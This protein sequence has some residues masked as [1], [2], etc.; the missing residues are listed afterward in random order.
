MAV[1][2][3]LFVLTAYCCFIAALT[4]LIVTAFGDAWY[5]WPAALGS[6]GVLTAATAG[7]AWTLLRDRLRGRVIVPQKTIAV[8]KADAK[9]GN[10]DRGQSY[11]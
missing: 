5:R 4:A 1:A 11:E 6:M 8:L 7:V 2:A 10:D 3:C 9:M